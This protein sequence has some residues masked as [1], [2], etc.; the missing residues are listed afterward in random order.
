MNK[1]GLYRRNGK[2]VYIKQPEYSEMAYVSELWGDRETMEGIGGVFNFS[3]EKWNPFYKKMVNPSDGKNFYCL[4]Y[5]N[6]D[7]P[8]GEVSF[9]GYDLITKTA[10]F[11]IKVHSKYRGLGYGREATSLLLEYYFQEFGG[12]IMMDNINN[13]KGISLAKKLNF[14]QI[15]KS[16]DGVICRITKEKFFSTNRGNK[17]NVKILMLDNM[18]ILDYSMPFEILTKA[19]ELAGEEI[20]L[21]EGVAFDEN[22][23]LGSNINFTINKNDVSSEKANIVIIPGGVKEG[24]NSKEII[25]YILKNYIECDYICAFSEGI[26]YLVKCK[27]L[28]G[29]IVPNGNWTKTLSLQ[30]KNQLRIVNRNYA[31][32]GKIMLSTNIMGTLELCLNL[33]KKVYGGELESKIC[34]EIGLK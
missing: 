10:R 25:E 13:E 31:D 22:I 14:E 32:N 19:N 7:I 6:K 23:N 28:E 26:N 20:F 16:R 15:G 34:K 8:V 33:V 5:N 27:E 24:K 18:D 21:V 3:T 11:N 1:E 4:I 2:K 30:E 29:I 9:H 17:K 12:N